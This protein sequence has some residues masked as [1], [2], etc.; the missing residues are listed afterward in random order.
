MLV[1]LGRAVSRCAPT[2][3]RLVQTGAMENW[4]LITGKTMHLLAD[5]A[6]SGLQGKR[7]VVS[8][9]AHEAA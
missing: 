4:G 8:T 6:T 1:S 5:E 9:V 3:P 7:M 2:D